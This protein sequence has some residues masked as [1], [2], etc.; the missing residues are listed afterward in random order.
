MKTRVIN[1]RQYQIL[2]IRIKG[3]LLYSLVE[4][5]PRMFNE[6][7]ENIS[8]C[9]KYDEGDFDPYY[10]GVLFSNTMNLDQVRKRDFPFLL[11]Y[12]KFM[13]VLPQN[14]ALE[15]L[16]GIA[17]EY[18]SRLEAIPISDLKFEVTSRFFAQVREFL[19]RVGLKISRNR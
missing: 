9:N 15:V 10:D 8:R 11:D 16:K 17:E 7:I 3:L 4:S 5:D 2:T 19:W 13:Q 6:I 12:H 18:Q 1:K 14:F